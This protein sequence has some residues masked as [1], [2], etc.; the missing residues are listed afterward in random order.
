MCRERARRNDLSLILLPTATNTTQIEPARTSSGGC[1][2]CY[3]QGSIKL[4]K[5]ALK[6]YF[7]ICIQQSDTKRMQWKQVLLKQLQMEKIFISQQ[8]LKTTTFLPRLYRRPIRTLYTLH[9]V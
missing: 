8:S 1:H 4:N 2:A 5:Q 9:T 6:Y 7:N 3:L